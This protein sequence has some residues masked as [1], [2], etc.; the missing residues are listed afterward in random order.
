VN[1]SQRQ[2]LFLSVV[3]LVALFLVRREYAEFVRKS[4]GNTPAEAP[5]IPAERAAA[6]EEHPASMGVAREIETSLNAEDQAILVHAKQI[7]A[8]TLDSK[9]PATAVGD[10]IDHAAGS[11]ATVKWEITNCGPENAEGDGAV[12]RCALSTVQFPD[13]TQF[14]ALILLGHKESQPGSPVQYSDPTLLWASYQR[15][16]SALTPAALSALEKIARKA[17]TASASS[18]SMK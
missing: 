10:W 18:S 14:Q 1:R 6:Q 11:S 5:A 17:R 16:N 7:S 12:P 13:N 4:G 15:G 2:L 9:L 3:I 8:S